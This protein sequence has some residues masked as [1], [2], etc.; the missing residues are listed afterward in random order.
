MKTNNHIC[1]NVMFVTPYQHYAPDGNRIGVC[2][3]C[4]NRLSITERLMMAA[5]FFER[6]QSDDRI[7]VPWGTVAA[8]IWRGGKP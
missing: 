3:V 6:H 1:P 5:D 8:N 2:D 4:W 7:T